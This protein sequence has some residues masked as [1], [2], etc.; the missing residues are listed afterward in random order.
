MR[1]SMRQSNGEADRNTHAE[2]LGLK[3]G[4]IY[5]A[6]LAVQKFIKDEYPLML[7]TRGERLIPTANQIKR[8][9]NEE[10]VFF[11][12]IDDIV[13]V[14]F[15]IARGTGRILSFLVRGFPIEVYNFPFAVTEEAEADYMD[16]FGNQA[17]T[18]A[19][20]TL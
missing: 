17:M 5:S 6:L 8:E 11:V 16:R 1:Q 4:E 18:S 9:V 2:R 10:R 12:C 19:F 3:R 7:D 20:G 14:G 13:Q 15:V